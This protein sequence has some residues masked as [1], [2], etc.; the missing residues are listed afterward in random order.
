VNQLSPPL[1]TLVGASSPCHESIDGV[2]VERNKVHSPH[3]ARRRR[4]LP[5]KRMVSTVEKNT[6]KKSRGKQK[7]SSD[8]NPNQ[9][10]RQNQVNIKNIFFS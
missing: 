10:R 4:R 9:S 8:T 3:V 2:A 1:H 7:E 5:Y 6:V